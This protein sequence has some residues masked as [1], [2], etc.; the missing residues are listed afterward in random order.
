MVVFSH[1]RS[2]ADVVILAYN[3]RAH[4]HPQTMSL[5]VPLVLWSAAPTHAVTAAVCRDSDGA[6]V[7]GSDSGQLCLWDMVCGC[8]CARKLYASSWRCA[9][10]ALRHQYAKLIRH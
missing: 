8:W 6:V 10:C 1:H 5:T 2:S 9:V 4:Q 3:L 7:T